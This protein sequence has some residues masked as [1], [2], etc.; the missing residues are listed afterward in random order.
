MAELTKLGLADR[1]IYSKDT[2]INE[3]YPDN[4]LSDYFAVQIYNKE[5]GIPGII[6][7]H[8]FISNS[9]DVNSIYLEQ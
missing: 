8:A 2:T 5:N 3:R 4:S 6:V 7:E 9:N 1:G